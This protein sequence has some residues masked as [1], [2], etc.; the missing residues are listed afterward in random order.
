MEIYYILLFPVAAGIIIAL[1]NSVS[2]NK[3]LDRFI[4][5]TENKK[6]SITDTSGKFSKYLS[7]PTC[8]TILNVSKWTS[9]IKN[10]GIKNATRLTAFLYVGYIFAYILFA[11]GFI[12]LFL[13]AFVLVIWLI[14]RFTLFK[15]EDDD[16][17]YRAPV[18]TYKENNLLSLKHYNRQGKKTGYSQET[19]AI[20]GGTK[21]EHYDD[22]YKKTGYTTKEKEILGD[23]YV[24]HYDDDGNKIGYSKIEKGILGGESIVHYDQQWE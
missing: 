8:W 24:Q 1:V 18:D 2:I 15:D 6:N 7:R 14:L 4:I 23:E 22:N 9:E 13:I 16:R 5:W 20:F 17:A 19:T 11:I 12:I 10:E 21:T 3:R